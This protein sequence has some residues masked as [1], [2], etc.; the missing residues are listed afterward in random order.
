MALPPRS[1]KETRKDKIKKGDIVSWN[2]TVSN[3]KKEHTGEVI[4][5]LKPNQPIEKFI[6]K[7]NK[8]ITKTAVIDCYIQF[9]E[10]LKKKKKKE[11]VQKKETSTTRAVDSYVISSKNKGEMN[12]LYWLEDKDISSVNQA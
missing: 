11:R 10:K 9:K 7:V 2:Y 6:N 12:T 3:I 4:S 1:G 8:N 5:I